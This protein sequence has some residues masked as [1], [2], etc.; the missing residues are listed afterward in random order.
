[1]GRGFNGFGGGNMNSMVR[2]MQKMQK[3]ME[4][5]QEMIDQTELEASSGGGAVKVRINGKREILG[6]TLDPEIVDPDDVEMLQD[7]IMVAINDAIAQI[8]ALNEKEM[9]KLTGGLN[10]PGL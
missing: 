2:Q 8:T 4:E 3:K 5:A 1:M 7:M 10:I 9:G 6:I